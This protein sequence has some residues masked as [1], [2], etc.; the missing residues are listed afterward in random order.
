MIVN[1]SILTVCTFIVLLQT[2][3]AGFE[4]LNLFSTNNKNTAENESWENLSEQEQKVLIQ[5]YQSMKELP[6]TEQTELQQRL[7]WFMQLSE[8]EQQQLREIWQKMSTQDRKE[9]ATKLKNASVN[10]RREI[11]ESYLQKYGIVIN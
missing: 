9:L 7:D 3:F 5:R 2:S 1:R 11:R 10:E 4:R 8:Q 6:P